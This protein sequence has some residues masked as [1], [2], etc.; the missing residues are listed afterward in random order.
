[1]KLNV[2]LK[3]P[4]LKLIKS[5]KWESKAIFNLGVYLEGKIHLIIDAEC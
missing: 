1:M 4:I 5:H 3:N 2:A